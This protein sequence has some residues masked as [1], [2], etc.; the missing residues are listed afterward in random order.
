MGFNLL[1]RLF[2]RVKAEFTKPLLWVHCASVGE[3]NTFL[4]LLKE[5]RKDY[6]IALTYFSPRAEDFLRSRSQY[7]E[8]LHPLPLDLP[9]SLRR[10]E[11]QLSP[12]ALIVV[13]REL[14]PCLVGCTRTK[15]ILVNAYAKGRGIERLLARR[16]DLI[17]TR[18]REDELR[19]KSY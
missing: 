17:L 1:K 13:E 3:F 16:F 18:G 11:R 8:L 14:W 10:F 2:P 7:W 5:L 19:F 4:P 12:K 15:K 6:S 9:F